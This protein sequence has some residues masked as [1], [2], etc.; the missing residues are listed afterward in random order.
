MQ[1]PLDQGKAANPIMVHAMSFHHFMV[2]VMVWLA[3]FS[4][5]ASEKGLFLEWMAV[6][7]ER[8]SSNQ[9]DGGSNPSPCLKYVECTTGLEVALDK[10]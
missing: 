7:V 10:R 2:G 4:V 9:K 6:A 3:S 1:S 8:L 5:P